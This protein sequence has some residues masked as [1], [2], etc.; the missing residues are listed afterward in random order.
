MFERNW[1]NFN[2][3]NFILDYFAID[4]K[5][6]LKIEP[7]NISFSL[8]TYLSK[9]NSLLDT[10]APLKKTSKNELIFKSQPWITPGLHK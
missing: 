7:K 9:I 6:L 4:W 8:E 3:E 10:H 1:S 2:Q 5:A